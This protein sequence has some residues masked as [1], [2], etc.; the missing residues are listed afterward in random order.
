M[1]QSC[2]TC[3]QFSTL[4]DTVAKLHNSLRELTQRVKMNF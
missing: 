1:E 4:E 2:P 3:A